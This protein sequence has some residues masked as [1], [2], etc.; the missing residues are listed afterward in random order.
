V[1]STIDTCID[2]KDD[3]CTVQNGGYII[4]ELSQHY[5]LTSLGSRY[6]VLKHSFY[7]GSLATGILSQL[8]LFPT[9]TYLHVIRG[10]ALLFYNISSNMPE[11]DIL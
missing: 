1:I 5:F 6:F 10:L 2:R 7:F 3:S 4:T 9:F 11:R 8:F